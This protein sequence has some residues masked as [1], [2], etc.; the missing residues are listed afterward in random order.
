MD[1]IILKMCLVSQKYGCFENQKC[2]WWETK[3]DTKIWI[4]KVENLKPWY[5]AIWG[6]FQFFKFNFFVIFGFQW[7]KYFFLRANIVLFLPNTFLGW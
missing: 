2:F 5:L 4:W 6:D 7:K 1:A 3:N